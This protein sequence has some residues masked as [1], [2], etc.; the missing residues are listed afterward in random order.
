MAC[1]GSEQQDAKDNDSNGSDEGN[2]SSDA[3]STPTGKL[4][5]KNSTRENQYSGSHWGR[6]W[7]LHEDPIG[8]IKIVHDGHFQIPCLEK[9]TPWLHI[10]RGESVTYSTGTDVSAEK[11][12]EGIVMD[13]TDDSTYVKLYS[14]QKST[15]ELKVCPQTIEKILCKDEDLGS[16]LSTTHINYLY[17]LNRHMSLLMEY[18]GDK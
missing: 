15:C 16:C 17:Q 6:D 2:L 11:R 12:N 4:R 1:G 8:Q 14:L 3:P 5:S 9:S 13:I 10:Y 18:L 7:I